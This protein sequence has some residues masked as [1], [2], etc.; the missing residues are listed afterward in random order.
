MQAAGPRE[1]AA[2]T[3]TKMPA[4]EVMTRGRATRSKPACDQKST[5][6][7]KRTPRRPRASRSGFPSP[8][9]RRFQRWPAGL[10]VALA[11]GWPGV[12]A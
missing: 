7:G 3:K 2:M 9:H 4:R 1:G 10:A 5:A 12:A 6:H 8:Y 11:P